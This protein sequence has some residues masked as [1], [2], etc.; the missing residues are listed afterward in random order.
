MAR[1]VTTAHQPSPSGSAQMSDC[2]AMA[3]LTRRLFHQRPRRL[4]DN[5][6]NNTH[7]QPL[8]HNKL[9][10]I[11]TIPRWRGGSCRF[12]DNG[13]DKFQQH[14]DHYVFPCDFDSHL[15]PSWNSGCKPGLPHQEGAWFSCFFYACTY[16]P[17][18]KEVKI[19]TKDKFFQLQ[20]RWV[21]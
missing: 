4:F 11:R 2:F 16:V 3:K 15:Y 5:N 6:N 9:D 8:W 20:F 12:V 18:Y 10:A 1:N 21:W 19:Q 7:A 14:K 17:S 13:F